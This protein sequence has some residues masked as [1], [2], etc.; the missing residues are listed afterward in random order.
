MLTIQ[1]RCI[2]PIALGLITLND[3]SGLTTSD[4]VVGGTCCRYSLTTPIGQVQHTR[5]HYQISLEGTGP[6]HN[7]PMLWV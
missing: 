4:I 5:F 7:G 3:H 1:R 6:R 2:V